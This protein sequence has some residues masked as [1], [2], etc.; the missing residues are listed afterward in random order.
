MMT[1]TCNDSNGELS[2]GIRWVTGGLDPF[3]IATNWQKP[4]AN[5]PTEGAAR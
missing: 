3:I 1:V 2:T 5:K 4:I